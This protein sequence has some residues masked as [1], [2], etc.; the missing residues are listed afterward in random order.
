MKEINS[1]SNE[2]AFLS[3]FYTSEV[4][5]DGSSYPTVEHAYQAAKTFDSVQRN[6]IRSAKTPGIAKKLGRKVTLRDDWEQEKISVMRNLLEQ[7]FS[8]P[9]LLLAL[10]STKGFDLV[11][12]NWWGD[13]F[14]GV[15]RGV[16]Q[17]WLGI[18]LMEIRDMK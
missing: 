14:W 16:G 6:E 12:G 15:C 9:D 3:N 5:L 2:F 7:K 18:L 1:F 8:Q 10:Q 11:E 4:V 17:N 13:V